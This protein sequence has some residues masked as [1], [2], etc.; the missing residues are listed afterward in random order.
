M[1]CL[2]LIVLFT[3]AIYISDPSPHPLQLRITT[4]SHHHDVVRIQRRG[5]YRSWIACPKN[6]RNTPRK[7][8]IVR[9]LPK[10]SPS[11]R[12]FRATTKNSPSH[13]FSAANTHYDSNSWTCA[14]VRTAS[15]E[16]WYS[17]RKIQEEPVIRW[18]GQKIKWQLEKDR[19]G[20]V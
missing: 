15:T 19:M 20:N 1:S 13:Y 4:A 7:H 6:R 14:P 12:L 17:Y 10:A 9:R 8:G 16:I 11:I 2:A 18:F 3:C 5:F